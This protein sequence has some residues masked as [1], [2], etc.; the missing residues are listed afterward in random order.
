MLSH[1]EWREVWS[2]F[3][4]K[5]ALGKGGVD[6]VGCW[7]VLW[8]SL[9][10]LLVLIG[11]ERGGVSLEYVRSSGTLW[12]LHWNAEF[13][14]Q[15]CRRRVLQRGARLKRVIDMETRMTTLYYLAK[16]PNR[17]FTLHLSIQV[18]AE[19]DFGSCF[20]TRGKHTSHL[21]CSCTVDAPTIRVFPAAQLH[22]LSCHWCRCGTCRALWR[23]LKGS[24]RSETAHSA[25]GH[26][27]K[28]V[29]PFK[30]PLRSKKKSWF[31]GFTFWP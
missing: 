7:V 31:L 22:S 30:T 17:Y 24:K 15:T 6:R 14:A 20:H 2:T 8:R 5:I 4:A 18:S 16:Q 3:L 13:L 1:A 23:R 26:G 27:S 11:L 10:S 25:M 28:K 19:F 9:R 29:P 21:F 12:L